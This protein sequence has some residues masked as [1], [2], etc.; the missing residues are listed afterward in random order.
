[1]TEG[2]IGEGGVDEGKDHLVE[3]R[4]V[5]V[6]GVVEDA[7]AKRAMFDELCLDRGE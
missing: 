2:A 6:R 5:A 7:G 1:M 4:E 3:T